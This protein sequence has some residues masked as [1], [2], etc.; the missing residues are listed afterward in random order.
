[1]HFQGSFPLQ[2]WPHRILYSTPTGT[3]PGQLWG[4]KTGPQIGDL[5]PNHT[6]LREESQE[7]SVETVY[8]LLLPS[9][10]SLITFPTAAEPATMTSGELCQQESPG[11]SAMRL[12]Y[13]LSKYKEIAASPFSGDQLLPQ[14]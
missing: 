6:E 2:K 7:V 4:L 10:S 1:M 12:F 9:S 13:F 14:L 5:F 3:S 11:Y 8:P